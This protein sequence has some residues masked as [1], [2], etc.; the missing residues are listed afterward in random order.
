M[1]RRDMNMDIAFG[2]GGKPASMEAPE[3]MEGSS[4]EIV[5]PKC[6][7]RFKAVEGDQ[8]KES[9]GMMEEGGM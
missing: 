5:C 2:G 9:E 7:A 8:E 1:N 3:V 6:G 4:D